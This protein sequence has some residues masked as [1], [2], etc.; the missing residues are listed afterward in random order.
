VL[1]LTVHQT[2]ICVKAAHHWMVN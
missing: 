2:A 1:F